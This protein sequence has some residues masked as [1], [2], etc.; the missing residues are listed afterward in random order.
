MTSQQ[1]IKNGKQII[2]AEVAGG[3]YTSEQLQLI[4]QLATNDIVVRATEDQRLALIV[5]AEETS[6]VITKLEEVGISYRYYNQGLHQPV[7]DFGDLLE[8]T[9]QDALSDA[10]DLTNALSDI[11]LENPLKIGM[12]S[13]FECH[14]PC[15]TLDISIVG[16]MG[17]Y[18]L[19]LGG[20]KCSIP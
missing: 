12:N 10:I 13:S 2:C 17:G 11:N 15:H 6:A 16:E 3:I 18:R 20:K 1:N 14:A 9:D 5:D 8:G 4:S 19:S 7:C